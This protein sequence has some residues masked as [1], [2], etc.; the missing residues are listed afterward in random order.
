MPTESAHNSN[1]WTLEISTDTVTPSY[2][3]VGCP[4][5]V[6]L[7]TTSESIDVT[8]LNAGAYKSKIAGQIDWSMSIDG[9][10]EFSASTVNYQDLAALQASQSRVLV[11]LT[12]PA[13]GD[14]EISGEVAINSLSLSLGVDEAVQYSYSLEGFGALTYGTV[15]P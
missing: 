11:K 3:A 9:F 2:V 5:S 7:D 12:G 10:V 13:T 14:P 4:Q 8:C 6:T 15:A 1:L